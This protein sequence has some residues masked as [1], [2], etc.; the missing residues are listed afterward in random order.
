M[1]SENAVSAPV[2]GLYYAPKSQMGAI[3]NQD[4]QG[5]DFE[6]V[7]FEGVDFEGIVSESNSMSGLV[8]E[9]DYSDE[10]EMEVPDYTLAE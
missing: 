3:T 10:S 9:G 7:D 2:S 6:G 8:M 4:F 5:V 1:W